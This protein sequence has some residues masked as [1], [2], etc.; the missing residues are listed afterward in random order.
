ME[1]PKTLSKTYYGPFITHA[2]DVRK[3]DNPRPCMP[4]FQECYYSSHELFSLNTMKE[5]TAILLAQET[6]SEVTTQKKDVGAN[7]AKISAVTL[8][9][10]AHL[11]AF[12][13]DKGIHIRI[14]NNLVPIFF[15]VTFHALDAVARHTH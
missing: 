14:T 4:I 10:Q 6:N 13:L 3:Y 9:A 15:C 11:S 12:D 2:K 8:T 1:K 7:F 5:Q